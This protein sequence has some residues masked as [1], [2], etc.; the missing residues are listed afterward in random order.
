MPELHELTATQLARQI[1][2]RQISAV[3][4]AEALLDRTASLESLQ[5][6]VIHRPRDRPGRCGTAPA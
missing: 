4:V 2:D 3:D 1:R 6:W 5:A